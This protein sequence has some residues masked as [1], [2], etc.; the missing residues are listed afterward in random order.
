VS[1][2]H[3]HFLSLLPRM[4]TYARIRFRYLKCPGRR[5]DA[6]A[7]VIADAWKL[8]LRL[9][10]QGKDVSG[11]VSSFA[12]SAVRHV[13]SGRGLCGQEKSNDVGSPAPQWKYEPLALLP[14]VYRP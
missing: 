3:A 4:V 6:V 10:A 12:E 14:V 9:L 2:L 1:D 5:E 8:H 13:R 7:E 11:F